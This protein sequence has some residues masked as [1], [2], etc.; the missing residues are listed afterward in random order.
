MKAREIY[1]LVG[2]PEEPRSTPIARE[3]VKEWMASGDL[4]ALGAVHAILQTP[5]Y[6]KRIAP[7][8]DEDERRCFVMH[9]LERC[10]KENPDTDWASTRYEA[11]WELASW[12][13]DLWNDP[14][15]RAFC[16]E[17]KSKLAALYRSG[18]DA[19]RR[20]LV[21][22]A[23]EHL[24]ERREI[25]AFFAD[26]KSDPVLASAYREALLWSEKGGTSD[27]HR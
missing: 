23:L 21:D 3:L 13:S 14:V 20:C 10:L 7:P 24:F 17:I 27:L 9:Y 2:P 4:D 26:W 11:G 15:A 6:S 18:D 22:A 5:Q 16:A 1:E 12:F 25:A 8:I 19:L